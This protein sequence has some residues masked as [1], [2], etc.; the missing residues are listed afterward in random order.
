MKENPIQVH[1]AAAPGAAANGAMVTKSAE[2]VALE[3]ELQ[4]AHSLL[5]RERQA[6]VEAEA[7]AERQLRDL[8]EE[9]RKLRLLERIAT[10]AN[11]N[12]SISEVL[13]FA[14]TA[15]CE[16]I[17]WRLGHAYLVQREGMGI[18]LAS[19]GIWSRS[20]GPG[21]D[22][23]CATSE[24]FDFAPDVGLPGRVWSSQV[25]VWLTQV[26]DEPNLPRAG[27]AEAAG[28][29][30]AFAF[31]VLIGSEVA[32]VI[33]LFTDVHLERDEEL[34]RLM[35]QVGTQLGRAVERRRNEIA[36][37]HEA[38]HDALTG[39][40]NRTVFVEQVQRAV[41][42][43]KRQPSYRFAVL[44]IDLDRF[45]QVNDSLGHLAG[46][47]L[48]VEMS[49][50]LGGA[51]RQTDMLARQ[52]T[53]P[54]VQVDT[55]ARLGGDEFTMFLD[56]LVDVGGAVRVAERILAA[57]DRPFFLEGQ[58]VFIGASIGI[59]MNPEALQEADDLLRN[60]DLA[61]YR[62][63]TAGK[64]RYQVFEPEMHVRALENLRLEA[65]L[66][67]AVA[68]EEFVL[69]YQPL[70]DFESNATVGFEA[71]VRWQRPGAKLTF[72][73]V[74]IR[75]V[76]DTG[77]IVALG[78]WVLREACRTLRR[79]QQAT[80]RPLSMAVNVSVR[81][82]S[83]PGFL[84]L[85]E[86]TLEETGLPPASLHLEITES[87]TMGAVEQT[88]TLLAGLKTLGVSLSMD[89]FGTGYSS[90]SYLHRFPLD[91]LK[92]DRAFVAR[93]EDGGTGLPIVK[94]IMNLASNLGMTVVAEGVETAR[95][96]EILRELGC[97]YAQGY[98]YSRP[99]P[100]L[101]AR[102]LLDPADG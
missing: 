51:I 46:D 102:A 14:L 62:A 16:F 21:I 98:H 83:Q 39:L 76:E 29:R 67:H 27:Q 2:I 59:V 11:E 73:D 87:L 71:L 25:P 34:L 13:Q 75:I 84:E 81:Q 20:P 55:L 35:G 64:G 38:S 74:F 52:Q 77:L 99:L 91:T 101:A 58:E 61:M 57:V 15:L 9:Q 96:G 93:I 85:V 5:D 49:R 31:P 24:S 22:E 40:P 50:R 79:W 68:R 60:A 36:L 47:R 43:Q 4:K 19:S 32:A 100:E 63:K 6:R 94:T 69:H 56:D 45:K 10:A 42:R 92:I 53:T 26:K 23:F 41:S 28:L 65:D 30:A 78:A 54:P 1:E 7:V 48:L 86:R 80:G 97:R 8:Y 44:F 18:R 17:D 90:L 33:E 89:D 82:L 3:E 70:I 72:P 88:I 95:Q 12:R 37:M 66:R